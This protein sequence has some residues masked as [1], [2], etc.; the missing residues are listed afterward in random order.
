MSPALVTAV[1]HAVA[2]AGDGALDPDLVNACGER[3]SWFCESSFS[4]THNRML[5]KAADWI[6]TRPLTAL[7]VLVVAALLNRYVRKAV[8]AFVTR[9]STGRQLANEALQRIGVDRPEQTTIV[10]TRQQA[11]ASTLAAVSRA[12]VSWFIWSI[13]VLVVL[14][15]FH[16]NLGPLLA[17]AGIAGIAVGFGA[18]ALVRD[19]ISG[20]FMLLEDQCGVGD[21]VDLGAAIGTVESITLRM[22]TVRGTDGTLW[23]VPNGV[24]QRVGNRTR[25]WSQGLVDITVWYDGDIDDALTA[26]HEGIAAATEIPELADVL[27]QPPEVLGVERVDASG[28]VLRVTVRTMPGK[29]YAAIRDVRG[30]IRRSLV[31]HGIP[32][33]PPI[34]PGR[35]GTTPNP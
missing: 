23:S 28:T 13:A 29:Q 27:L 32:L 22:T 35:P 33:H 26:V 4:L 12:S 10:D 34:V 6:V 9:L 24:I 21:E 16:I 5:A 20:F 18:Q 25:S 2:A 7:L 8:T 14:G 19:C 11:R 3:P 1:T 30:A 31:Q 15:L 17:G